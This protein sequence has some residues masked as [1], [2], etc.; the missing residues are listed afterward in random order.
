MMRY[1]LPLAA[2]L[3]AALAVVACS[4][5]DIEPAEWRLSEPPA[6][7][8]LH[9]RVA[10]GN[11]CNSIDSVKVDE[12]EDFVRVTAYSRFDEEGGGCDDLLKI[13][14]YEV[15]LQMPLGNRRLE[16]CDI[17][18][19]GGFE[20]LEGR[21]CREAVIGSAFA[22]PT[23][24]RTPSDDAP[25]PIVFGRRFTA[26]EANRFLESVGLAGFEV[27]RDDHD[28][29]PETAGCPY[30]GPP[31]DESGCLIIQTVGDITRSPSNDRLTRTQISWQSVTGTT[32]WFDTEWIGLPAGVEVG[33]RDE[34]HRAGLNTT[35]TPKP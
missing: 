25:Y 19:S 14:P 1:L 13:D 21:T 11:G 24:T 17:E 6:G 5:D 15:H 34:A 27:R 10:V 18:N 2:V 31:A 8:T 16:G 32:I 26:A 7:T 4:D 12:F 35:P 3:L 20:D 29:C 30:L 9:I 28:P 23:P 22:A 33:C